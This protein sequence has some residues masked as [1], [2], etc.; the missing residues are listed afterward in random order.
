MKLLLAAAPYLIASAVAVAAYHNLPVVGP[1]ARIERLSTD[2]DEWRDKAREW[3]AY[4]RAEKRAF[5][6][7]E[8]LRR[9]EYG[10]GVRALNDAAALCDT[11]VARARAS[12]AAIK[13]IVTKEVPRDPQG[14]PVRVL[15]DP[16]ELREAI[17]PAGG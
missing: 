10:Q 14:C 7:S 1:G 9:V 13:T 17:A 12:A 6:E 3:I 15:V 4:G 16:S 2:R 8:R 11:R 5:D